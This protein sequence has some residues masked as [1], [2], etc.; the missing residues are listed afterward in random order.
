[1]RTA[2]LSV[3][4]FVG[5]LLVG[6]ALLGLQGAGPGD[7]R[8]QLID[9]AL[10]QE[11]ATVLVLGNSVTQSAV[12]PAVLAAGLG[13]AEGAVASL[14]TEGAGPGAWLATLER[15][16]AAGWAP[17]VLV[18]Y[19]P[20][21]MLWAPTPATDEDVALLVELGA[22]EEAFALAGHPAP[23]LGVRL[24]HQR[25]VAQRRLLDALSAGL[26]DGIWRAPAGARPAS[27]RARQAVF[28]EGGPMDLSAQGARLDGHGPQEA[29][30]G[31]D[32]DG[33]QALMAAAQAGGMRLVVVQPA[34]HPQ[35]RA[36][37]CGPIVDH[38]ELEAALARG[39]ADL[40]D[41]ATALPGYRGFKTRHHLYPVGKAE[42]SGVL[43]A[44]LAELQVLHAAGAQPGRRW[45]APCP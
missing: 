1:M 9:D 19:V 31:V 3:L 33:V 11:R 2:L 20:L 24:L 10:V 32:P 4:S 14:A 25:E 26:V 38:P 16:Q 29:V 7:P 43:A 39:G 27:E 44:G 18:L 5:T 13:L 22:S 42:L 41:L 23:G 6:G 28:G 36:L 35:A 8:A 45:T 34:E 37:A 12:D 40:L 30:A 21:E 15:A 17:A